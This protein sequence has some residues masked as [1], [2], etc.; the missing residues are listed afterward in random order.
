[1]AL[2]R[3]PFVSHYEA[4]SRTS[5]QTLAQCS[6]FPVQHGAETACRRTVDLLALYLILPLCFVFDFLCMHLTLP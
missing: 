6:G 1:M 4:H 3:L 2:I 5:T